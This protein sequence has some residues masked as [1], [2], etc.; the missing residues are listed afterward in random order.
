MPVSTLDG[1]FL[2]VVVVDIGPTDGRSGLLDHFVAETEP[3]PT[4]TLAIDLAPT[5]GPAAVGGLRCRR[6]YANRIVV[7]L[8]HE[9]TGF[10]APGAQPTDERRRAARGEPVA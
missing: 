3:V 2:Y 5:S 4:I 6:G 10:T 8:T 1:D 7:R 9:Q